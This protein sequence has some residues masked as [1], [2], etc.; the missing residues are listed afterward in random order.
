MAKAQKVELMFVGQALQR[1]S[2]RIEDGQAHA[3]CNALTQYA[4]THTPH[5]FDGF[6]FNIFIQNYF[7]PK[8]YKPSEQAGAGY[9][10]Q[11][12]GSPDP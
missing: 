6:R 11:G 4:D 12:V 1:M 9:P 3:V 2:A 8:N 10:P 7:D 5:E